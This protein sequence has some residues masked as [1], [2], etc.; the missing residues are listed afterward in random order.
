MRIGRGKDNDIVLTN[1]SVSLNHAE[2]HRRREGGYY[3]V[4]LASTNGVF[5]NGE[6]AGN[7]TLKSGDVIE[8]GEVS[9][10][11]LSE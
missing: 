11:F 7:V 5:V 6:K 1:S 3:L 4:D 2:I 9:L 10:Q 8:L